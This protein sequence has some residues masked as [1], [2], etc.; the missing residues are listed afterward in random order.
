M[1]FAKTKPPTAKDF[2]IHFAS[3]RR[4]CLSAGVLGGSPGEHVDRPGKLL[5]WYPAR[6]KYYNVGRVAGR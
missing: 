2:A 5:I 3:S 1:R 4:P 6:N